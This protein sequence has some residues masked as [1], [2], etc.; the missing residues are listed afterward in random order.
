M[1]LATAILK[2]I[3]IPKLEKD[4]QFEVS[5]ISESFLES[6]VTALFN[7]E[8]DTK[9]VYSLLYTLELKETEKIISKLDSIF[10]VFIKELAENYVLGH[11]SEIIDTLLKS[12]N[13]SFEKEVHFFQN[14]EKAIIKAERKRIKQE[15]PTL[16][17]KHTFELSDTEI[18]NAIKKKG[19]QD[20][21]SK[22]AK[23]DKEL[24][25]E[26]VIP[27]YSINSNTENKKQKVISLYWVK[28]AVAAC[29]VLGLGVWFYTNQNQGTLPENN[30]V[31]AP[32]KGKAPNKTD[33]ITA[34]PNEIVA[35]VSTVS[36][37][38]EVI[39]SNSLGFGT[40]TKKIKLIENNQLARINSISKAIEKYRKDLEKEFATNQVGNSPISKELN[41]RIDSLQ[42]ELK[43]LKVREQHY[44]FDGKVL[45]L[46]VSTPP[47]DNRVLLYEDTYYLKK[48]S[49][50][51]KLVISNESQPYQKV[52]DTSIVKALDKILFDNGY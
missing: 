19:R 12:K 15:L 33:I 22:I 42:N 51:Y 50:F 21:K 46:Y 18:A 23:W 36:I 52:M 30:V 7:F 9:P 44:I 17:E 3:L 2:S 16:Y 48:E 40:K 38:N 45:T 6:F 31:T 24:I 26:E 8:K 35:E 13:S 20:L 37:S 5:K 43:L 4:T 10:A 14:L 11:S 47:M 28:Y 49:D 34:I 27:V 1:K 29:F 41:N 32:D 39:E 25:E